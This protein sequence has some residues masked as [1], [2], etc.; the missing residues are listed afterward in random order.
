MGAAGLV[1]DRDVMDRLKPTSTST[2]PDPAV[3]RRLFETGPGNGWIVKPWARSA[4]HPR[5]ASF[6]FEI[7]RRL[8]NDTDFS[9]FKRRDVPGLNFAAIG[10]SYA[11][12]TARDTADRLLG[13]G[14]ARRPART[15][16][17][18]AIALDALDLRTR[19]TARTRPTSTSG[20]S[21]AVSWGPV[22]A[23]FIAV[24]ALVCGLLA[25]FKALGASVRLVGLG[26][27]ILD[28]V[29][30][31]VGV[32]AVAGAMVGGT[33]ALRHARRGVPP[34]VRASRT[35]VPDAARARHARRLAR[36]PPR[37]APA[38]ARARP[39]ASDPRLER[40]AS[41]VGRAG[42]RHCAALAPAAGYLW[43]L[44]LLAVGHRPAGG[45][46]R[47]TSR[48]FAR[49]PSSS[50][51]VAGTLW[52][53]DTVEL[54]RFMVALFGRLPFITPI[55]VYPALMLA[56]GAMVVP[57]FIAAAAAR[58]TAG[59]AVARHRRAARG[60]RGH[61]RLR[62]RLRRPTRSRSRSG[63]PRACSSNPTPP[64]PPT[65]SAR[66]SRGSIS[67]RPRRPAGTAPPTLRQTSV[68]FGRFAPPY[69]FRTTA[70]V[71]RPGAGDGHRLHAEAGRRR[72]P[73]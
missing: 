13:P 32:A 2:R 6:A 70:A 58:R 68:P 69:V 21:V 8:P 71:A 43:T 46:G 62:L 54:L 20:R 49:S 63:A 61:D 40:D 65:R 1:T 28:A 7:Y 16:S 3:R 45:A 72:A 37:R 12:H 15:P 27:W 52:L 4:P 73:S 22:T 59:A 48:R 30:A 53:C 39:A 19:T 44:P 57:P 51:A 26:R 31:L 35:A 33:W 34:V 42:G 23:W 38:E 60:G 64:P 18:T 41:A 67:M 14:A 10:D 29:W 66:R 9:V 55:W 36:G 17:Q 11:Y 47:R 24:A 50:L 56:C 5:G 25:W